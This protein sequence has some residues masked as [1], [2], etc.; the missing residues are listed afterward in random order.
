MNM[1]QQQ[2]SL[3]IQWQ[4]IFTALSKCFFLCVHADIYFKHWKCA[5]DRF[6]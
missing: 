1:Q 5:V 3:H 6:S 4:S 2:P